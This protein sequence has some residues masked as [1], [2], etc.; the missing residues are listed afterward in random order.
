[1]NLLPTDIAWLAGI[2]E[3][4]GCFDIYRSSRGFFT[5]RIRLE[6]KDKD[7]VE[8]AAKMLGGRGQVRQIV[9]E[10][11]NWSDTYAFGVGSKERLRRILPLL[12][13]YMGKRRQVRLQEMMNLI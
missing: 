8:R 6:M 4:E 9:R 1:M 3:G 10:N 11:E 13:P 12:Y 2:L 5:G 7:I